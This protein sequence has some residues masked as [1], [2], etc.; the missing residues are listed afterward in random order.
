M[1]AFKYIAVPEI[2]R[3]HC[4]MHAFRT[5]QRF[6][7]YANSDMFLGML[8]RAMKEI[9][10]EKEIRL[11]AEFLSNGIR[12]DDSGFLAKVTIELKDKCPHYVDNQGFCHKCGILMDE[13]AARL[14]GYFQEGMIEGK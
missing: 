7:G 6:G 2:K 3:S 1:I 4:D 10:I 11:N 13:S 5:S 12:I 8:K 14:S 9:G